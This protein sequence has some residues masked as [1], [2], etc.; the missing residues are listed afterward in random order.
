MSISELAL[1]PSEY[2]IISLESCGAPDGAVARGFLRH[3]L[4]RIPLLA[5]VF[6]LGSCARADADETPS[7]QELTRILRTLILP[8]LPNPLVEQNF[9]WGHQEMVPIG[10]KWEMR[11]ILLKP[12]LMK[13]LHNDGTCHKIAMRAHSPQK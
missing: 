2:A 8:N 4:M 10:V 1:I 5:A 7:P 6:L 11:G 9:N 13:K 3:E 12:E